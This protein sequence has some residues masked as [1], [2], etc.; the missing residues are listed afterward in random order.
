[1]L[2]RKLSRKPLP[3]QNAK[4]RRERLE[5]LNKISLRYQGSMYEK[6]DGTTG[7]RELACTSDACEVV[8]IG[9]VA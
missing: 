8:D 7:S 6:E 9:K 3:F 5:R 2:L 4:L 1:M